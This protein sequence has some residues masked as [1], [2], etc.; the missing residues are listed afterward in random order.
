MTTKSILLG[1]AIICG[2]VYAKLYSTLPWTNFF[3][4]LPSKGCFKPPP[5]DEV[6]NSKV[7]QNLNDVRVSHVEASAISS[8][9]FLQVRSFC[10]MIEDIQFAVTL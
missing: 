2:K 3:T 6:Y 1:I 8:E 10:T 4:L 5:N 7:V 9:I